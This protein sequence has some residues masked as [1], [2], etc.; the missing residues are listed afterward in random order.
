MKKIL[1]MLSLICMYM[2]SMWGQISSISGNSIVY[3]G[4]TWMYSLYFNSALAE[5][6]DFII[7]IEYG[8]F[9]DS[10]N[11]ERIERIKKGTLRYDFFIKWGNPE[12]NDAKI[13]AY[14]SGDLPANMKTLNVKVKSTTGEN[15]AVYG[16]LAGPQSVLPGDTITYHYHIVSNDI[17]ESQL[18]WSYDDN[19][20]KRI[21]NKPT[22]NFKT[23]T[24]IVKYCH[25]QTKVSVRAEY[26]NQVSTV[27]TSIMGKIAK[28][29]SPSGTTMIRM[30]NYT[31]ALDIP[32]NIRDGVSVAWQGSMN[33]SLVSG[34]GTCE[35][36]YIPGQIGT[37]TVKATVT[38]NG[39][40]YTVEGPSIQIISDPNPSS[41]TYNAINSTIDISSKDLVGS[42]EFG[43]DI[44]GATKFQWGGAF[45]PQYTDGKT[46]SVYA[47]AKKHIIQAK[48]MSIYVDASNS[49]ETVRIF[50]NVTVDGKGGFLID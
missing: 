10:K 21:P 43:K 1:L 11:T 28:I 5:D 9:E 47:V 44:K 13:I 37:G 42:L 48:G 34:Q 8:S 22:D 19:Y 23:I 49:S 50:Y 17:Y 24:F 40:S 38:S 45:P 18:S 29:I 30:R 4:E 20:L 2:G 16:N 3:F 6:T 41:I 26:K 31:F 7:K 27:N 35:A 25:I 33:F 12:T 46:N 15:G 39:Q 36:V 32:S 14:K